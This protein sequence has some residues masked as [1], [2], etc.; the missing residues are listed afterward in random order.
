M[1]KLGTYEV[2]PFKRVINA[3]FVEM[4]AD[5]YHMTGLAEIDVTKARQII[6]K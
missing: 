6:S 5:T 1:D 4:S 3:E 2:K